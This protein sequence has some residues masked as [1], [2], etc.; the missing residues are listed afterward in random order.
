MHAESTADTHMG[1]LLSVAEQL[2]TPLTVIA[3]QMELADVA[4]TTVSPRLVHSQAQAALTLVDSYLLGLQLASSQQQLELE[5]V[6]V[7]SMLADT[8]HQLDHYAKQYDVEMDVR[9]A[10]R[11]E[12]VMA[13]RAALRAAL[14]SLG[15]ALI[16]S[17]ATHETSQKRRIILAGHRNA[18]GIVAGLYGTDEMVGAE[19]RKALHLAG[20]AHQPFS[21]LLGSS[22]AG[23]FVA[24]TLAEAMES[25]LRIGRHGR[26]TGL[27]ITLQPSKQLQLV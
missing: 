27:A 3:R 26:Q 11:Y 8:V 18:H 5:P 21:S 9:I 10:G 13:H 20:T 23:I 25:R 1:M 16:A 24:N 12:P 6:S 4:E 17:Q 14:T 15:Y 19:L 22:S 2:K 7:S